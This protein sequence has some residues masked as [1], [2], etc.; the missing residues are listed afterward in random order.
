MIKKKYKQFK[1]KKKKIKII[2]TKY[3]VNNKRVLINK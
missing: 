1:L 2:K 3:R